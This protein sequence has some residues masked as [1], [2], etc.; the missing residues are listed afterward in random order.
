MLNQLFT[1]SLALLASTAAFANDADPDVAEDGDTEEVQM[2]LRPAAAPP[3]AHPW[4]NFRVP[5]VAMSLSSGQAPDA[6]CGGLDIHENA[7]LGS[8]DINFDAFSARTD[9]RHRD[10]K[11]VCVV[12]LPVYGPDGTNRQIRV[13]EVIAEGQVATGE[14][15]TAT[16][17]LKLQEGRQK[18]EVVNKSF[19]GGKVEG[20]SERA[21][22]KN[23]RARV[24]R[25]SECG[26]P[27]EIDLRTVLKASRGRNDAR[28]SSITMDENV[29]RF[30]MDWKE[31]GARSQD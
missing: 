26:Q 17:K 3:P 18:R 8:I 23:R 31:C 6:D 21:Q 25:W 30:S 20:F 1:L 4:V 9:A 28:D 27:A 7:E 10:V 2:M 11:K 22:V 15:G 5:Q 29:V 16:V 12:R 13:R 24:G 19:S 14:N